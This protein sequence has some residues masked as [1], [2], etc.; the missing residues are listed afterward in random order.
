MVKSFPDGFSGRMLWQYGGTLV[1]VISGFAYTILLARNLGASNFGTVALAIGV[2]TLCMQ[3]FHVNMRDFA[4]RYVSIGLKRKES[5]TLICAAG[6][7]FAVNIALMSLFYLLLTFSLKPITTLLGQPEEF[8]IILGSPGMHS[9]ASSR[10]DGLAHRSSSRPESGTRPRVHH[11]CNVDYSTGLD[12]IG[13]KVFAAGVI[14]VLLI[15]AASVGIGA[16]AF[17]LL[18]ILRVR[19]ETVTNLSVAKLKQFFREYRPTT[20]MRRNYFINLLSLPTKEL[21]TVVLGMFATLDGV[22]IY[23][24]AKNFMNAIWAI[25]DPLHLVIYPELA[26]LWN[27]DSREEINNS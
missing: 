8:E 16:A 27:S 18:T 4:I 17:L 19:S 26:R 1:T 5:N 13:L 22:G 25:A 20:F 2:S 3:L 11:G 9:D 14:E 15:S 12:L 21:D 24:V 6:I 10:P 7:S 23:R